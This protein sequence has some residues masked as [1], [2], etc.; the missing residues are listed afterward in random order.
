MPAAGQKDA[1]AGDKTGWQ[2]KQ[3]SRGLSAGER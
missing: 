3:N 1:F 2:Q